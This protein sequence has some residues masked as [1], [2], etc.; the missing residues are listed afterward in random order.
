MLTP[1]AL[2]QQ[3]HALPCFKCT[4]EQHAATLHMS[5]RREVWGLHT[6]PF[7]T[8]H[9]GGGLGGGVGCPIGL[10]AAAEPGAVCL[11]PPRGKGSHLLGLGAVSPS[12]GEG[13]W[14]RGI[15]Y[16]WGV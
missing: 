1:A 10:P 2:W 15:E 14:T 8:S 11:P 4:L 12:G 5:G 7:S 6:P 3:H 13:T 9:R 16:V